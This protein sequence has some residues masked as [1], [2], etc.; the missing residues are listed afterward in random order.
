[1]FFSIILPIY[2]V[3]KYLT[4]C[5]DSIVKQ[6]FTDYE[7][8][9]VDDGSTDRSGIICDNYSQRC[10][11]IKVI[12]KS[13]GGASE[14]RNAGVRIATGEYIIF[15]DSDDYVTSVYFLSDIHQAALSTNADIIHYWF[16]K[17]SGKHL[18]SL[19]V[20]TPLTSLVSL[21]DSDEILFGLVKHD[22]FTAT[23]WT[24]AIKRKFLLETGV[25]FQV[26]LTGEDN[27][28]YLNLLSNNEC[29]IVLIDHAYIA[30]RQHKNSI[31]RVNKLK[32]LTDFLMI[33]EKYADKI[34]NAEI[35][36]LKK[37]ALWGAM[38]KYYSHLLIGYLS[39][40]APQKTDYKK[41]IQKLNWLL[42]YSL[43]RRARYIRTAYHL[44]GFEITLL[45][46]K[47]VAI[48]KGR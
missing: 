25:E 8:I 18:C 27:D 46:L 26:G 3:E 22:A 13:N 17:F 29:K 12:H 28:W 39:C 47:T 1:M 9:L 10:T 33:V 31:S 16:Q 24:K 7:L 15:I 42:K 34:I 23:P 32:N 40:S 2:N 43:G 48:L 21:K 20:T 35:P 30:Y 11:N 4:E 45:I 44:T 5:I 14:A 36:E 37:Q 19:P 6:T 38:A 41:R